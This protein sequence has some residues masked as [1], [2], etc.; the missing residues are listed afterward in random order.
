MELLPLLVLFSAVAGVPTS[1]LALDSR[2]GS[3]AFVQLPCWHSLS[4][5]R[6]NI[7]QRSRRKINSC[8]T[9]ADVKEYNSQ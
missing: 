3:P 5:I 6:N 4:P 1:N 7:P 2:D 8:H 9:L